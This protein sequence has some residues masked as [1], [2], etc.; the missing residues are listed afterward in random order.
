MNIN[1]ITFETGTYRTATMEYKLVE[2]NGTPKV[3]ITHRK[4]NSPW[5]DIAYGNSFHI[6]EA[7]DNIKKMGVRVD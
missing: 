2:G 1:P 6:Q 4:I 7:W 3:Q 5:W